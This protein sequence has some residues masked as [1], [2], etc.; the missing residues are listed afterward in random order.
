MVRSDPAQPKKKK[1]QVCWAK[2]AQLHWGASRSKRLGLAHI[3]GVTHPNNNIK[4][5]Q[6]V[7]S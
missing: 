6:F 2:P 5:K 4:K 7:I 1:G 3:A